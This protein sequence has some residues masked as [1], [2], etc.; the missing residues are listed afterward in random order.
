MMNK[1]IGPVTRP[2]IFLAVVFGGLN[3]YASTAVVII[4]NTTLSVGNSV[5]TGATNG[6]NP[7]AGTNFYGYSTG[8]IAGSR[9]GVAYVRFSDLGMDEVL[10]SGEYTLVMRVASAGNQ[11]WPGL[12]DLTALDSGSGYACGFFTTVGIGGATLAANGRTTLNHMADFNHTPGVSYSTD[13]SFLSTPNPLPLADNGMNEDVWYNVTSRWVITEG[14]SV[15]GTDPFVGVGFEVG[16]GAG[17]EIYLDDALL[18]YT[19]AGTL[20]VDWTTNYS[21]MGSGTNLTADPD[22]DKLNNLCEYAF[23]GNPESPDDWGHISQIATG[24][25]NGTNWIQ[26]TCAQRKDASARGLTYLVE[27]R[28]NMVSGS[29]VS[30]QFD[31]SSSGTL[32]SAFNE[33]TYYTSMDSFNS[34]FL[35]TKVTFD[36]SIPDTFVPK[37]QK[38]IAKILGEFPELSSLMGASWYYNWGRNPG[39]SAPP[40]L[41]FVSMVW[42][43]ATNADGTVNQD[44]VRTKIRDALDKNPGCK[45]LLAFNEPDNINQANLSV[46]QVLSVWPIFEQEL[47]GRNIRLGSPGAASMNSVWLSEFMAGASNSNYR[48]DFLCVHR[49]VDFRSSPVDTVLAQC[50]SLYAQ[51]QIP[52]WITELELTG[53]GLTET[54]VINI[55]QEWADRLE[56]DATVEGM[57]ERY[58]FAYAPP[59]TTVDYKIVARPYETNDTL[60]AFG[61]AFQRLHE[62]DE[63]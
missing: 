62:P 6:L 36:S 24:L 25:D 51:Y 12:K 8:Y 10:Q 34:L 19:S 11:N 43:A 61:R 42:G 5:F 58:A 52:I 54:D 55:W 27:Q 46:E 9:A 16:N 32:D 20:Y 41:E 37:T 14:S 49:R 4:E 44:D 31:H 53:D 23:G 18:T 56:N 39:V 21:A 30:G 17:E 28:T 50:Q 22:G 48:V 15:I 57:V 47:E 60:T 40:N 13:S 2:S 29:W 7:Y 59:D 63:D 3:I 26:Y 45:N 33:V 38:S 1:E 35:R